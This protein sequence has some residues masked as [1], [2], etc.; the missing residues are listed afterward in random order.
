MYKQNA[1][2]RYQLEI[3]TSFQVNKFGCGSQDIADL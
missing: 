1:Q 3:F 2:L